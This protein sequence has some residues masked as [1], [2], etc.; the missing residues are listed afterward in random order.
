[1]YRFDNLPARYVL[2][3]FGA[4]VLAIAL[5]GDLLVECARGGDKQNE[6]ILVR[7]PKTLAVGKIPCERTPLGQPGDYKA[8]VAVLPSGE[9][10]LTMFHMHKNVEGNKRLEQNVLYRSADSGKTWSGPEKLD[11]LGREPYLTVLK[12]GTIFITGHLLHTDIRNKYGYIHGYVHRSTDGGRTWQS[13]RIASEGIRPGTRG[14]STRNVLELAN[15]ALMLGVDWADPPN[16]TSQAGPFFMWRSTDGGQT[17]DRSQKC[18]PVGFKSRFGFFGGEAWLWQA[19]SGKIIA[20]V[21]V[22]SNE[23]PIKRQGKIVSRGDQDDHEMI[24]ESTDEGRT[25]RR[26]SDFGDYGQMYPSLLRL[27]DGRLLYTYTQR[28]LDP[29]LGVRALV[30]TEQ[31]D[32]FTFDFNADR[33]LLDYKTGSRYQG[34]GFGPTVQL[35]D[36]AL[37][38]SYT[39]RGE[40]NQT[41][42]EVVR[43]RLPEAEEAKGQSP[44]EAAGADLLSVKYDPLI[45]EAARI[46]KSDI[47]GSRTVKG[48]GVGF[49][50]GGAYDGIWLSD[51][52]FLLE[53][54]RYWG[55][56]YRDFL[57]SEEPGARGIA[58]RFAGSQDTDGLIPMVFWGDKGKVDYGGRYDL[59]QNRKQNRDMES[60]YTFVHVNSIYWKDTGD[61]AYIRRLRTSLRRALEPI[62]R[63]RDADTG[64]ILAAYGPPNSDVSVDFAV[65]QT[66]AHPY[67]NALYV[68]AYLEY[69]EMA[70]AL[71]D[72][73]EAKVYRD[74]SQ[75]L[76]EAIN[77]HLW[78]PSRRR[79]ETRILRT[80]VSTDPEL[81]ASRI[82]E[83]TRFPVVDNMLL[84]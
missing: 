10:L 33:L 28:A 80:P 47:L 34:G 39:Y 37:V 68:R 27:Q 53:A 70:E 76:R 15:G 60:P 84:M 67:F 59:A 50:P 83:D 23:F 5:G 19:R 21:R 45:Q 75:T 54:Y 42:A 55:P 32:G 1:M 38:T 69:A 52:T 71:G 72:A 66:T 49:R 74:R 2:L 4:A 78:I 35:K 8:C 77:R 31:K 57:Y 79:Y 64:L 63:R 82:K 65:P 11:L 14:R 17:W 29:P 6:P 24:W 41:H 51:C 81:P 46:S 26:V 62:D 30:G 7:N 36:G 12:D 58:F 48:G 9:L 56:G 43:W 13:T 73:D 3:R 16:K 22:E 25:F 18:N 40:D 44:K 61:L 20:F